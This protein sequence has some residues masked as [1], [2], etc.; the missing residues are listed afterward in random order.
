MVGRVD[1]PKNVPFVPECN[2]W[3][4]RALLLLLQVTA[5]KHSLLELAYYLH[6]TKYAYPKTKIWMDEN[7]D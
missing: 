1:C 2:L 4:G 5:E 6:Y 7:L 3:A